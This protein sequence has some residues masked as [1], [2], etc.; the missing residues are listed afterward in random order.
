MESIFAMEKLP[1]GIKRALIFL[2]CN[3]LNK[4]ENIENDKYK[5]LIK[6][7][8][9]CLWC[10]DKEIISDSLWI[11]FFVCSNNNTCSL[12]YK[13]PVL[14]QIIQHIKNSHFEICHPALR[15]VGEL[16]SKNNEYGLKLVN[17]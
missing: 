9:E 17:L 6:F 5:S 8:M 12:I 11:V 14:K 4:N 3:I 13:D 2:S 1:I 7:A 10:E 15:C 16:S